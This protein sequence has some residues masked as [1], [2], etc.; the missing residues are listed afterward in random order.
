[1]QRRPE[2]VVPVISM[3]SEHRSR[4]SPRGWIDASRHQ[5]TPVYSFNP[6]SRAGSN[7]QDRA[8]AHRLKPADSVEQRVM[9]DGGVVESKSYTYHTEPQAQGGK[10]YVRCEHCGRECI[11]ADP[12]RLAHTP[13]CPEGDR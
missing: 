2:K 3:P 1:M 7:P 6:A 13:D 5:K 10:R 4:V 9:A 8:D 12:E 11:P